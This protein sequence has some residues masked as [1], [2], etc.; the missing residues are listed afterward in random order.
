VLKNNGRIKNDERT[1]GDT[2]KTASAVYDPAGVFHKAF[3]KT[4]LLCYAVIS[5]NGEIESLI[6]WRPRWITL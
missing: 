6:F 2:A 3:D 4:P 5:V 1:A